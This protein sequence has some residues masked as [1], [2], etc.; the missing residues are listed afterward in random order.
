MNREF[1]GEQI[2]YFISELYFLISKFL[3]NGPLQNASQV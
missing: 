3:K 1:N 2:S